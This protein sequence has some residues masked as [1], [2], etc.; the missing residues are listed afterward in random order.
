MWYIAANRDPRAFEDPWT[1]D[2]T[3]SPNDHVGF[4]G[5]GPHFC[6]GSN[7]AKL[8]IALKFKGLAQRLPDIRPAGEIRYPRSNFIGGVKSMPVEPTPTPSTNTTPLDRLG[9]ADGVSGTD[10]YGGAVDREVRSRRTPSGLG[11]AARKSV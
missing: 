1:S 11:S 8:E 7:L 9:S 2:I 6:L 3:R 10:G 5:G 4:G